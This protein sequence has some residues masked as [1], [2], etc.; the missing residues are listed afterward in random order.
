MKKLFKHF[1]QKDHDETNSNLPYVILIDEFV[2]KS[3]LKSSKY[4]V[5]IY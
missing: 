1:E 2:Q 3:M 4:V 5:F